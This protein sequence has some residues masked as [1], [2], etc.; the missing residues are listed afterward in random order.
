[1]RAAIRRGSST[2]TSPPKI[3][4]RR[5][6]ARGL[7]R[8]GRASI[9]QV[10]RLPQTRQN[11]GNQIDRQVEDRSTRHQTVVDMI[12]FGLTAMQTL[13]TLPAPAA[14]LAPA[15]QRRRPE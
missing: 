11:R 1:M 2:S 6:N 3:Q 10:R 12:M 8:A 13:T 14:A 15:G 5:W 9:T 7:P 4:Q